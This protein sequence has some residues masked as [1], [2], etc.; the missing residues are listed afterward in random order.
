LSAVQTLR[1]TR[2]S[3]ILAAILL[4][5]FV[6]IELGG[7][8]LT[9]VVRGDE[10]ATEFQLA[11]SRAGHMHA[12]VLLIFGLVGLVLADA[13]RLRG[14][15]GY[16]AR[17]GVPVA[18]LLM[19]AG[20]FLSSGEQGATE[21]ND[22]IVLVWIGAVALAIGVLTLAYG[23]LTVSTRPPLTEP[24]APADAPGVRAPA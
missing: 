10:Q 19:S 1:L 8:Y 11:F 22:L 17:H 18:A 6:P 4:M 24:S 9:E 20:F 2:H 13:T 5:A 3:R 14:L 21:P 23:L 16:L 7:Y 15:P 12:S